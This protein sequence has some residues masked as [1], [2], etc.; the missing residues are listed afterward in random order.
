V[1]GFYWGGVSFY[2]DSTEAMT[3][4]RRQRVTQALV[5]LGVDAVV[6]SLLAIVSHLA[7]GVLLVVLCWRMAIVGVS[8]SSPICCPGSRSTATAP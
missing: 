7:A 2:V 4:P 6:V 8:T 5:G 1:F 3:L